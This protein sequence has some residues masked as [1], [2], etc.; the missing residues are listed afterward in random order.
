MRAHPPGQTTSKSTADR[1]ADVVLRRLMVGEYAPGQRLVESEIAVEFAVSRGPVREALQRLAADG[2]LVLEH[3]RGAVVRRMSVDDVRELYQLREILEGG[4]AALAAR[5]I[6]RPGNRA[7]MEEALQA[8]TALASAGQLR[9]YIA[10]NEVFHQLIIELAGSSLLA[11]TV[12]KLRLRLFRVQFQHLATANGMTDSAAKHYAVCKAI[13]AG[14]VETAER[15]MREHVK[16]AGQEI[17]A[18]YA[19]E[20]AARLA[21]FDPCLPQEGD[22]Q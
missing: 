3:N 11:E 13:L 7:R 12:G 8:D 21:P 18:R 9:E 14:D 4:A 19:E 10:H 6:D 1:V 15:A 2:Y 17:V 20:M 22:R 16:V 5:H